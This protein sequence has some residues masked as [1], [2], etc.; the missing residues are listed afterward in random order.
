MTWPKIPEAGAEVDELLI[1]NLDGKML[2]ES[3]ELI[4]S[5]TLMLPRRITLPGG[6][7]AMD[8]FQEGSGK[9]IATPFQVLCHPGGF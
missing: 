5:G 6:A 9:F 7:S 1:K 2:E 8:L 4:F 3:A